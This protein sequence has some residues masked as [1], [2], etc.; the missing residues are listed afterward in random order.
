[1][2]GLIIAGVAVALAISLF[3]AR[4]SSRTGNSA[5]PADE[6]RLSLQS[7]RNTLEQQ[8]AATRADNQRGDIDPVFA[9]DE[10]GRLESELLAVLEALQADIQAD[11]PVNESAFSWRAAGVMLVL[12]TL[13]GG[14]LY[15]QHQRDWWQANLAGTI[16]IAQP[17][18]KGAPS[19][20]VPIM[21]NGQPDIGAMVNRLATRL[22]ENPD[23]GS[24]W[25]RLGRSYYVME[26]YRPAA[27]AYAKAAALLPDDFTL[28]QGYAMSRMAVMA[29][30]QTQWPLDP[31]IEALVAQLR[32]KVDANPDDP[33]GF[34]AI[35]TVY[36]ILSRRDA[37]ALIYEEILQR[38]PQ[39]REIAI[40]AAS[41]QFVL[42]NG[43][44]T[45][46]VAQAYERVAALD[47][48]D[49]SV[50][51]YRGYAAF[52]NQQWQRVIDY[53]AP[54]LAQLPEQGVDYQRIVESVKE[55]REHLMADGS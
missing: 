10:Q 44:L 39:D 23:D 30:E 21:A 36:T 20:G 5:T 37:A 7:R 27:E 13:V 28:I 11:S 26:K 6:A 34:R 49:K 41:N 48:A 54:L 12:M 45:D 14:G 40:T 8:I 52:K 31:S 55:A 17:K 35:A 29:A 32:A 43:E 22:Q 3:V 42:A 18:N 46:I 38:N 53:W 2:I 24:G 1:M 25:K 15:Y 51:W 50:I 33:Q 16:G 19:A 47:P 9:Q 4:G